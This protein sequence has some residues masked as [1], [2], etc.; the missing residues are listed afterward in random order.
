MSEKQ[1]GKNRMSTATF[2][3]RTLRDVIAPPGAGVNIQDRVRVA[4]RK[5]GWSFTRTKDVWYA[6]PRVSID[7]D[8]LVKI[9]EVS[10]I[11]YGRA[12]VR[13]INQLIAQADALLE[14]AD[15][16]FHRPFVAAI[17]AFF[18]ALDRAGTP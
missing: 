1:L 4:A 12:E 7:G 9:E 17:R 15:E 18:S 6:D 13:S 5:L 2:A 11:S 14:G 16:D 3:Q 8:E 10:G